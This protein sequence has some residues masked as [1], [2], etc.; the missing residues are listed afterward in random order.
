M[1]EL[2]EKKV[3]TL[4]SREVADMVEKRHDHLMRD[5][6][7]Y[8]D[9]LGQTPSLGSD[10]FF[11]ESS[12]KAGTG[13]EY[14]CYLVTKKGCEFIAHKLT[15]QKGAI[16]TAT[17][18]NR[19]HQLEQSLEQ[20]V[21]M[22]TE[23]QRLQL[24]IFQARTAEEA[25]VAAANLDRY[26]R[27]QLE[28]TKKALDHKTEVIKGV[29]EDIDIYTKRN[30]LNKVVRYKGANFSER[31]NELYDRYKEVYSVDLRA[32]C[33]GYNLKQKIGKDKLS[34]VKYAE[35]F[36]HI[37]NLYKIALKLYETDIKEILEHLKE[38][39]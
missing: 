12:Y 17:Y 19:F 21:T 16:F 18:I 4:D 8:I 29:P 20:A 10:A 1:N 11:I 7:T 3:L 39:A 32:R 37:D 15:G 9:Y 22:L 2:Q 13:K 33:E 25:G 35:K 27:K 28:E 38:I 14:K 31:W 5:I 26:R 24:A 30:V 6:E 36:G 34:V 23:E